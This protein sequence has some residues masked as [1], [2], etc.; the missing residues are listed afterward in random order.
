MT[1]TRVYDSPTRET[2]LPDRPRQRQRQSRL[3]TV[4]GLSTATLAAAALFNTYRARKVEREHPP[5][6]HFITVEGV[7][8]HYLQQ[9][10]GTPVVLIHGNVMDARDWVLSGVFDR[11]AAHHRVIAFDRPGF[12]HSD[13]PRGS[14]WTAAHQAT[15][16]R[17]AFRELGIERPVV[18]GHSWGTL[19]ALELALNHPDAV[20]G[21]VVLSG[22]YDATVRYDVPLVAISVV[23]G[24]GDIMRYTLSPVLGA[25]LLPLSI[26]AMFSP[27]PVP[28]QFE[29]DFPY[30][31][32]VR[33]WQIRAESQDAATMI[34]AAMGLHGRF[35]DLRQPVII[36]AGT[37]DRVVGHK[38]HANWLHD[39]IPGS[40]LRLINGAGHMV[41]YVCPQQV[42]DCIDKVAT[43]R[44]S[45]EEV[46]AENSVADYPR[47]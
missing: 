34:P 6:G 37:K 35:R 28:P 19:V 11:T 33:P 17:H 27:Q 29:R 32:P 14:M 39:R 30:G 1:A 5:K 23:P 10:E 43:S 2:R 41:H 21:L 44:H 45:T 4:L 15:L 13:R 16:L 18:V 9:G 38:S 22:Y 3:G 31:F 8:L 46:L 7:Q 42:A 12:G 36:M 40:R 25:A 26:K 47:A 20:G 24:L